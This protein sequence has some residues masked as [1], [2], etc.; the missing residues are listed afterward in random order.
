MRILMLGLVIVGAVL[1][2]GC[3]TDEEKLVDA[4][5]DG[6][7][8]YLQKRA[9]FEGWSIANAKGK[10]Y[11]MEV[12]SERNK[13][14]DTDQFWTFKVLI[15]GFTVKNRFNADVKSIASCNGFLS[16]YSDGKYDPPEL[17]MLEITV[18]DQP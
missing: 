3:K 14:Y 15:H 6:L 4:C 12:D 5:V 9:K 7:E 2:S 13:K 1:L 10:I 16:K 17:T 11:E 8:A 18:S